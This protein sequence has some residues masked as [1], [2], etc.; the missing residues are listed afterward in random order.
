MSRL[1]DFFRDAIRVRGSC[2]P[3]ITSSVLG[4]TLWAT[5]IYTA[6]HFFGRRWNTSSA[7]VGPLS[8][9]VGLLL[10]FRNSASYN[11]WD[12]ARKLWA[13]STADA[14]SL[15]RFTWVNTHVR[16]G[17]TNPI[18]DDDVA[19]RLEK[20]K[21]AVRLLVLFFYAMAHE[22]RD[23]EGVDWPDYDED[24]LPAHMRKLWQNGAIHGKRLDTGKDYEFSTLRSLPPESMGTF[25]GKSNVNVEDVEAGRSGEAS[26]WA[27]PDGRETESAPL[28]RKRD[29]TAVRLSASEV[30]TLRASQDL[31]QTPPA[32]GLAL[33]ALHELARY[34]AAARRAGFFDDIGPAGFNGANQLVSSLTTAHASLR[35][36]RE[37]SIP[38]AYGIHLKQCKY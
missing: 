24:V 23:E 9:V 16:S 11:R 13:T 37:A 21:R 35:R 25:K 36:I 30:A 31:S 27:K 20:K 26:Q 18:T 28:L 7:I 32:M 29:K 34:L 12:E 17:K 6:D 15:A 10:V 19:R 33:Y 14:H 1:T 22:L 2:L 3:R 38:V 5:L 4:I 8:V